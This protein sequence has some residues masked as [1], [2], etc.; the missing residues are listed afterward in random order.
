MGYKE[1]IAINQNKLEEELTEQPF[2]YMQY[3]EKYAK[4]VQKRDYVE[5]YVRVLKSQLFMEAKDD[6]KS[7][8]GHKPTESEIKSWV[9]TN[10]KLNKERENLIQANYNVNMYFALLQAFQQRKSIL[11]SL[12]QLKISGIHST[13]K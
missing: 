8:W 6:W 3:A 4:A 9:E 2:L 13:P 5:D 10:D 1:D 11:S 12:V 7:I